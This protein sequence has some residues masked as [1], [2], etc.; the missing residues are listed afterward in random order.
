MKVFHEGRSSILRGRLYFCSILAGTGPTLHTHAHI[1][2]RETHTHIH[3]HILTHRHSFAYSHA[4][5]LMDAFTQTH[6]QSHTHTLMHT[7]TPHTH[8]L[9]LSLSD[10]L[11]SWVGNDG[12]AG[13]LGNEPL[14]RTSSY[15]WDA[16]RGVFTFKGWFTLFEATSLPFG[17]KEIFVFSLIF[18]RSLIAVV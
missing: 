3:T 13:V 17:S 7:H 16:L 11:A 12:G 4:H 6:T 5:T 8:C 15:Y 9:S 10:P 14:S 2:Y 1:H 18:C